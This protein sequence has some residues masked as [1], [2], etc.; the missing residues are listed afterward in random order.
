MLPH[1]HLLAGSPASCS[2]GASFAASAQGLQTTV[3]GV[4]RDATGG[5]VPG[6]TIVVTNRDRCRRTVDHR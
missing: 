6:A 1:P 3:L 4:V 5:V 2:R